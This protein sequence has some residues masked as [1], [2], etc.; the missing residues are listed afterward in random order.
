MN[1]KTLSDAGIDYDEGLGRFCGKAAMYEKY[2]SRFPEDPNFNDMLLA[3]K[4]GRYQ[5]AFLYAHTLKGVAGNLSL[6]RLH[7]DVAPLV[8]A[9]RDGQLSEIDTLT[10]RARQSYLLAIA[11]IN[12]IFQ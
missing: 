2:L 3:L 8:E 11:A 7:E 6:Y 10:E 4:Q 9:L 12:A 5:D 1:R